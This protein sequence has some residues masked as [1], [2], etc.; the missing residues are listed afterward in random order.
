[1]KRLFHIWFCHFVGLIGLTAVGCRKEFLAKKPS[2]NLLT[3]N[4][5]IV[6][7]ELL[8]NAAVMN[9]SP[10]LGEVSADNFYLFQER[11]AQLDT[12][13]QNAYIWA[14]DIYQ[15]QGLVSDWDIPYQQVFYANTVLEGL[16][17][18]QPDSTDQAEWNM[19]KGWALFSRSFAFFNIVQLF[20]KP[21]D[22]STAVSDLGIPIRL[23]SDINEKSTRASLQV[24]YAQILSD[25]N[26]AKQLLPETIPF[27]NLN[28]P[29]RPA[30]LA[31]LARI[32]LSVRDYSDARLHAD[33]ALQSYSFLHQYSPADSSAYLPFLNNMPEVLYQC[34]FPQQENA[35]FLEGLVCTACIVD[36]DL[37]ASY[38]PDDL[39]RSAYFLQEGADTFILKGT[40]SG[41][42]FPFS[43]LAT[44]EIYLIRAE[45]SARAGQTNLALN[46]LDT[47]LA[48]RWRAG[49]FTPYPI[50]SAN[51]ALD[52]I[53]AERRKELA[54]R[55]IRWSDL[56]RLNQEGRNINLHRNINGQSYSLPPGSDLYTLP[57]PPDVIQFSH[58]QQ[59][60]R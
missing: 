27:N 42:V 52:T 34:T 4:S 5:L 2:T 56:R 44:D 10:S 46:D 55:G 13:D 53:L 31:L 57:I 50:L 16:T 51:E 14:P 3:P 18:I 25:L 38:S 29:S 36:T 22:S 8:D 28:R 40:Y 6:L 48:T 58:I 23:S 37:I 19:L 54:F 47:L 60:P 1:M 30:A 15:G 7:Q 24:S 35:N 26:L 45:C 43:G 32:Y 49:T 20:A 33:S 39:R 12:K 17:G 21:Y 59:N 11:W 41:T 9:I